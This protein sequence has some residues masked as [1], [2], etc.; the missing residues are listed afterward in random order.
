MRTEAK[1][2]LVLGTALAVLALTPAFAGRAALDPK[3]GF[4]M[5]PEHARDLL[6]QCSRATPQ[7]VTGTWQPTPAQ[8]AEL[9]ARLIDAVRRLRPDIHISG[10]QYA[11]YVIG[12]KRSIYV[13]A[14]PSS[15]ID[16][17]HADRAHW[18]DKA[19]HQAVMVCDGGQ[20][21]F[22]ALYDPETKTFTQFRFN[23]FA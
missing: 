12:G 20:D 10:R 14:F 7:D 23:G 1:R 2:R 19:T 15:V 11:G 13:N 22:G 17:D 5:A 9:D 8:T 21:F 4:I 3:A 16:F 18:A 6:H